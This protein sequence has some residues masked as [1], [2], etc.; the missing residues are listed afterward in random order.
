[1]ARL[2]RHR[3]SLASMRTTNRRT[4]NLEPSN[5]EP[6]NLEPPNLVE[7][8]P[9]FDLAPVRASVASVVEASGT[10][11]IRGSAPASDRL[12][13][14]IVHRLLQRVGFTDLTS[15]DIREAAS[16]VVRQ[17]DIDESDDVDAILDA[18]VAA[19]AAI[20][21]RPDVRVLYAAGRPIHEVPFTMKIDGQVVR[22]T[23]DCL[24]ETAPGRFTLLEFKTGQPR[25]EHEA[26]VNVYLQA[27]KG[28]FPGAAIDA[29]LVYPEKNID[30]QLFCP[31]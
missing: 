14:T 13:G 10:T 3:P 26:Q 30:F 25:P 5:L 17:H 4:S 20:C 8:T 1:M 31:N 11:V 12:V 28:T 16:R 19:Y 7:L 9:L 6:S 22:G 18:A 2:V 21:A 15:L 29:K 23:V 24:V 27:M